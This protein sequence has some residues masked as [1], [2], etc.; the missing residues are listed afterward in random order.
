MKK[1]LIVL[2]IISAIAYFTKPGTEDFK[3]YINKQ[4]E[5][6][7]CKDKNDGLISCQSLFQKLV[8]PTLWALATVNENDYVVITKF[9]LSIG[10]KQ[11]EYYGVFGTFIPASKDDILKDIKEDF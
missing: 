9:K 6:E 5:A 4:M 7:Y 3:K 1:L 8:E 2:A 11:S 10:T